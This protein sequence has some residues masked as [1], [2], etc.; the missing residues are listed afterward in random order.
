ME[1]SMRSDKDLKPPTLNA[2][3]VFY[4]KKQGARKM[5]EKLKKA[6]NW[7]NFAGAVL[8]IVVK[9]IQEVVEILP[10]KAEEKGA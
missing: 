6:I 9:V 7:I 3:G 8:S 5:N 1:F 10:E 4:N 2:S